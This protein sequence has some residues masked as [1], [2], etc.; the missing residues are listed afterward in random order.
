MCSLCVWIRRGGR[1][2]GVWLCCWVACVCSA[3]H[4]K[5]FWIIITIV[6]WMCALCMCVCVCVVCFSCASLSRPLNSVKLNVMARPVT[7]QG[8]SGMETKPLGP[9]RQ[10]GDANYY[11]TGTHMCGSATILILCFEWRL[12]IT[13]FPN[14]HTHILTLT[15][16]HTL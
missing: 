12:F 9:G 6:M 10:V 13:P 8:V 2:C 4:D 3:Y 5:R 11:V 1:A 15:L 14:T 7:M 16:S